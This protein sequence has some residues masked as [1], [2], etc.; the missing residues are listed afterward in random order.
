MLVTTCEKLAAPERVVVAFDGS[1]TVR[2]TVETVVA[3]P[4]LKAMP[5][6]LVMAGVEAPIARKQLEA[7]C[8]LLSAAGFEAAVE[9]IQAE[10]EDVLHEVKAET[11][12]INTWKLKAKYRRRVRQ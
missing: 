9:I 2:K 8:G 3:S 5:I 12:P 4:R 7:S 10:P 1:P 11:Y 6:L